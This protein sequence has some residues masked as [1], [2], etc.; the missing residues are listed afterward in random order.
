MRINY[1]DNDLFIYPENYITTIKNFDREISF[2]NSNRYQGQ[3][4]VTGESDFLFKVGYEKK[5]FIIFQKEINLEKE[6]N[7]VIQEIYEYLKKFISLNSIIF[8]I[9]IQISNIIC[10]SHEKFLFKMIRGIKLRNFIFNPEKKPKN[11]EIEDYEQHFNKT[12]NNIKRDKFLEELIDILNELILA[13]ETHYIE[14]KITSLWNFLEHFTNLFSINR[15]RNYLID[16]VAFGVLKGKIKD[17][18]N[19]Y[20]DSED[21]ISFIEP[22]VLSQEINKS[23]NTFNKKLEI[24][25]SK[26]ELNKFK[27]DIRNLVDE[28]IR[29][30]HIL[31][32]GYDL[33]LIKELILNQINK[34]PGITRLIKMMLDDINFPLEADDTNLIDYFYEAR[35]HLYHKSMKISEVLIK[36]KELINK[37][38]NTNITSFELSE[39]FSMKDKFEKLILK[40]IYFNFRLPLDIDKQSSSHSINTLYYSQHTTETK[41]VYFTKKLKGAL[42]KYKSVDRYKNIIWLI[43]K[44]QRYYD[45]YRRKKPLSGIYNA[46]DQ[47]DEYHNVILR[48]ENEFSGRFSTSSI[49]FSQTMQDF[50]FSI[51]LMYEKYH[52]KSLMC[53]STPAVD[54]ITAELIKHNNIFS[55]ETNYLDFQFPKKIEEMIQDKNKIEALKN[56]ITPLP[57]NFIKDG[58]FQD[59]IKLKPEYK[60]ALKEVGEKESDYTIVVISIDQQR[61]IKRFSDMLGIKNIKF[62][63]VEDK[64]IMDWNIS[65]EIK[66]NSFLMNFLKRTNQFITDPRIEYMHCLLFSNM[67]GMLFITNSIEYFKIYYLKENEVLLWLNNFTKEFYQL[68]YY[69]WLF[70]KIKAGKSIHEDNFH[71]VHNDD[72]KKDYKINFQNIDEPNDLVEALRVVIH[73]LTKISTY[74]RLKNLSKIQKEIKNNKEKLIDPFLEKDLK[75]MDWLSLSLHIIL[76]NLL[77]EKDVVLKGNV[78]KLYSICKELKEVSISSGFFKKFFDFCYSFIKENIIIEISEE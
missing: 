12:L 66:K 16:K 37:K 56:S 23:L 77:T 38:E 6:A 42:N 19:D 15:Q 29:E 3:A 60:Q 58:Y 45:D 71:E 35:N 68:L 1:F 76:Y 47:S 51:F 43:L 7:E 40:I 5:S 11:L 13:R 44:T 69:V 62:R 46:S 2:I 39:L 55:F 25:L 21:K 54:F 61:E 28:T 52:I 70:L 41:P 49:S 10:L 9:Q 26:T 32:D 30:D 17:K 22:K 24:P 48:F 75:G 74:T 4:S 73:L 18:L 31:V 67:K 64:I 33:S 27:L 53:F 78:K 20:L 72:F 59:N 34:F 63:N 50:H 65:D 14:T 36:L 8:A 57:F